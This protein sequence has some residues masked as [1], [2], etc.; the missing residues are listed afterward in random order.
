M[1][2]MLQIC[3][4]KIYMIIVKDQHSSYKF[5]GG[6]NKKNLGLIVIK[7]EDGPWNN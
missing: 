6:G 5:H 7:E 1:F 3:V 2:K 4:N